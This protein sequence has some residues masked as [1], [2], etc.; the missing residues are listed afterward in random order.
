M[1]GII[2]LI[3]KNKDLRGRKKKAENL[4]SEYL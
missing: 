4:A 3:F 1:A 2:L